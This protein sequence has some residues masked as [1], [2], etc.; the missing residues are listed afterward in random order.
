MSKIKAILLLFIVFISTVGLAFYF[1][2]SYRQLVQ[3]FFKYFQGDKIKFMGK[4]FN[5]LSSPYLLISFGLFSVLFAFLLYGHSKLGR[6]F[7]LG[8]AV[9]IFL[10]TTFVTSYIDSNGFIIECTACQDGVRILSYNEINYDFHF[11]T[12]LAVSLIPLVWIFFKKNI[13]NH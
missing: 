10:S 11:I 1:E 8:L 5:L 7:H 13:L 6:L 2:N 4:D 12:S 9:A 3:Y